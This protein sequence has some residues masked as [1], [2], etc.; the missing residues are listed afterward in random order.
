MASDTRIQFLNTLVAEFSVYAQQLKMAHWNITGTNF[1]EIHTFF[2]DKY[3]EAVGF[4]DSL[5]EQVRKIWDFPEA[6]FSKYLEM[7]ALKETIT[8]NP[9]EIKNTIMGHIQKLQKHLETAIKGTPHDLVTQNLF[10]DCKASIDKDLWF[11]K[12]MC[13]NSL[14]ISV[15]SVQLEPLKK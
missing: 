7:S 10:I 13:E 5:A 9:S 1:I 4:I 3:S 12:S 6:S 11:I 8:T 14:D 15:K 2:W